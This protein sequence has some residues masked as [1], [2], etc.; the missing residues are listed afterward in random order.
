MASNPQMNEPQS[1]MPEP[2]ER[3]VRECKWCGM[4]LHWDRITDEC[5]ICQD[6]KET[7]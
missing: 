2:P 1:M 7:R 6:I 3:K 5:A 4:P